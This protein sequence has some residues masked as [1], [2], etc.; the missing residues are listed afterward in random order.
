MKIHK[1]S[2]N[3]YNNYSNNLTIPN[4][5]NNYSKDNIHKKK[6]A[7]NFPKVK[8]NILTI[9][10][11]QLLRNTIFRNNTYDIN[12]IKVN[13]SNT[14]NI[15][16]KEKSLEP[17]MKKI[18]KTKTKKKFKYNDSFKTFK[19]EEKINY[20]NTSPN[21]N[22]FDNVT[23]RPK[24]INKISLFNK[25]NETTLFKKKNYKINYKNSNKN[26]IKTRSSDK[27]FPK[28]ARYIRAKITTLDLDNQNSINFNKT[29]RN[30]LKNNTLMESTKFIRAQEKWKRNY[31]VTEIQRVFR[32]YLFRKL[33][34]KMFNAKKNYKIYIKKLPKCLISLNKTNISKTNKL[35]IKKEKPK[36]I[37]HNLNAKDFNNTLNYSNR[38]AQTIREII[39]KKRKNSPIINLNLN[40]CLF[41]GYNNNYNIYNNIINRNDLGSMTCRNLNNREKFL[42]NLNI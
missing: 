17:L 3:F 7:L 15:Y 9:K 13:Q 22:N 27:K 11:N 25:L 29:E 38:Q 23:I 1:T 8:K 33:F 41:N 42:E 10:K 16:K 2:N 26:I 30:I 35:L 5:E 39:I 34:F 18:T 4:K 36:Y 32:G 19:R 14:L 31:F 20:L 40:N 12:E 28:N 6:I 21:R 24:E 37:F